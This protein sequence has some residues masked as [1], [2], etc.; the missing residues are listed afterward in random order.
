MINLLLKILGTGL[1]LI[2]ISY[3]VPGITVNSFQTAVIAGIIFGLINITIKPILTILAFPIN[4][5]TLGFF[6]FVINVFCFWLM[7]YFVSG[8]SIGSIN[9]AIIGSIIM[10]L[11]M[12]LLNLFLD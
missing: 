8:F 7:S 12:W 1:I 9:A 11:L 6:G 10:A 2:I 4:I 5:I 3:L